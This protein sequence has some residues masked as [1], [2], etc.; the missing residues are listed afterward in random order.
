MYVD[1]GGQQRQSLLLIYKTVISNEELGWGCTSVAEH[2]S[3]MRGGLAPTPSVENR[4]QL[5]V[6]CY[7]N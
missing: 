3:G 5:A 2:F 4:K 7:R 6:N 1:S